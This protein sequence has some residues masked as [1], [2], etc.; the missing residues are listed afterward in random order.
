MSRIE[1]EA[2]SL[3][4]PPGPMTERRLRLSISLKGFVWSRIVESLF[5]RKNSDIVAIIG[6]AF[7][8]DAD[9]I[10]SSAFVKLIFARIERS[11]RSNPI[12]NAV[13]ATNLP[14]QR[15]RRFAR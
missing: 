4:T 10:F 5:L 9:V 1:K 7:T 3:V 15:T 2:L 6:R 11:S 8:R 13:V 12:L 14:T